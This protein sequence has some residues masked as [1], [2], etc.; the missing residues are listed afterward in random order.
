L[1]V[2]K[3]IG[4]SLLILLLL[5]GGGYWLGGANWYAGSFADSGGKEEGRADRK[6]PPPIVDIAPVRSKVLSRKVEAVGTT[7]ARQSVDIT[8]AASGRIMSITFEPGSQVQEGNT[9]LQ[10]DDVVERAAVTEAEAERRQAELALNRGRTLAERKSIPQANVDELE[11]AFAA[12]DARVDRAKKQLAER[13]IDAP[14]AG[15]VGMKRVDVGARV[16]DDTIIT[17]LDDLGAV[18]VE[19]GVPEIFFGEVAAGQRV[20]ATSAAFDER[21]FAGIIQTVDSRID[22]VS[23]SFQVRATVPNDDLALPTGMFML[24]ELTLA[25]RT[26][27]TVPEDAVMVSGEQ[28]Q[29]FVVEDGKA[30]RR[31]VLIGQRELGFVEI[32][33]GVEE[34]EKVVVG[35]IQKVRPGVDVRINGEEAEETGAPAKTDPAATAGKAEPSA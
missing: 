35:G 21:V 32:V 5:A 33:E 14:F 4:L 8:S 3:Q 30:M 9:L 16:D 19:F 31:D 15:K 25:E 1:S 17:T 11:A 10:L 7:R 34:D 28:A 23:R 27:L 29:V 2:I 18:E 22:R 26:A 13:R 6:R 24:V 12:A 20:T